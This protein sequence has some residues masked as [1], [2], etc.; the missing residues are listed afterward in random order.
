MVKMMND[1]VITQL[2]SPTSK[3]NMLGTLLSL[4]LAALGPLLESLPT[5]EQMGY[6]EHIMQN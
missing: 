2:V 4:L 5:P 1:D 3:S 6:V